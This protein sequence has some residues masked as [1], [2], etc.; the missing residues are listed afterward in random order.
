M[1]AFVSVVIG[2]WSLPSE[3]FFNDFAKAENKVLCNSWS[4]TA[5]YFERL[6]F[7]LRKTNWMPVV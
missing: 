1:P 5:T 7:K 2:I 3:E 4:V 6:A